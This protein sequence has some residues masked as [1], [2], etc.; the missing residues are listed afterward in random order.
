MGFWQGAAFGASADAGA[1]AAQ[2]DNA[3]DEI[4][5]LRGRLRGAEYDASLFKAYSDR[6]AENNKVPEA[7][8]L[9]FALFSKTR[10]DLLPKNATLNQRRAKNLELIAWGEF[11]TMRAFS[12]PNLSK[13]NASKLGSLSELVESGVFDNEKVASVLRDLSEKT[14][15]ASDAVY[16]TTPQE[17]F[18]KRFEEL[19]KVA[20]FKPGESMPT[21]ESVQPT[22][23][24]LQ[25][26]VSRKTGKGIN[27]AIDNPIGLPGLAV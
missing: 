25:N 22:E 14:Q 19:K 16:E 26:T 18:E 5:R 6:I 21:P 12:N 13:Q 4:D 17:W 11:L 24:A 7:T 10:P 2:R 9:G 15:A 3:L 27:L 1:A 23:P 8:A 20:K